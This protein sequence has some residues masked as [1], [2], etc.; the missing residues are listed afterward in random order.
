MAQG[1]VGDMVKL[2]KGEGI[3]VDY[4]T[5]LEVVNSQAVELGEVIGSRTATALIS[6]GLTIVSE[7]KVSVSQETAKTDD[8]ELPSDLPGRDVFVKAGMDFETVKN[9]DFEANKVSGIGAKTIEALK[10]YFA[11]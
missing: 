6:G 3:F 7:G 11:Q 2:A 8:S 4:E 1:K 10:A 5:G 9:H